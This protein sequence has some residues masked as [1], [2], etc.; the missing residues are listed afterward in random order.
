MKKSIQISIF[1]LSLSVLYTSLRIGFYFTYYIIDNEGFTEE[2]CRN[3]DNSEMNCHGMCKLTDIATEND[4]KSDFDF[5][6]NTFDF[7]WTFQDICSYDF[8]IQI[9]QNQKINYSYPIWEDIFSSFY[10]PPSI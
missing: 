6:K 4:E 9:E 3:K 2:F 7:L 1:F 10:H 8:L 5:K